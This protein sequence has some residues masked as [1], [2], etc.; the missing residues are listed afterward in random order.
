MFVLAIVS[1]R[2]RA[3]RIPFDRHAPGTGSYIV[4]RGSA[5][6]R[7]LSKFT[8]GNTSCSPSKPCGS[9]LRCVHC[10]IYRL[11][12]R[13]SDLREALRVAPGVAFV[14]F[15]KAHR[16]APLNEEWDELSGICREFTERGSWSRFKKRHG[17]TGYAFAE[18][19]TVSPVGWHVHLHAVFIL[20]HKPSLRAFRKLQEALKGRWITAASTGGSQASLGRQTVALVPNTDREVIAGYLTKQNLLRN[21]KRDNAVPPG[22]LLKQSYEDFNDL[23]TYLLWHEYVTAAKGRTLIR[24]YGT[25]RGTAAKVIAR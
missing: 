9:V 17:I 5:A 10:S 16:S 3:R 1:I 18:E 19:T 21:E 25:A 7:E 11:A 22:W 12:E 2:D 24:Q 23:D 14:T 4:H 8:R 15:T 6:R 20:D 13:E